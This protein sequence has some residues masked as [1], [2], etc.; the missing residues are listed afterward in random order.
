MLT[1]SEV[2]RGPDLTS[3]FIFL[4]G[5]PTSC[6]HNFYILSEALVAAHKEKIKAPCSIA[7]RVSTTIAASSRK[8]NAKPRETRRVVGSPL[9]TESRSIMFWRMALAA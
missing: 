4:A 7:F 6:I 8:R 9:Y 1:Q 5:A 2:G 3:N